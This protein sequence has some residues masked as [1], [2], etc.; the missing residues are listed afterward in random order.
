MIYF[1]SIAASYAPDDA[2]NLGKHQYEYDVNLV[3]ERG[4][5]A[6]AKH[7][8]RMEMFGTND[9]SDDVVLRVGSRVLVWFQDD[10]MTSGVILGCL[11]NNKK[12]MPI[13][14]INRRTRFNK[15]EQKVDRDG[16]WH[17]HLDQ[18]EYVDVTKTHITVSN[19]SGEKIVIDKAAKSIAMQTGGP[20]TV[21]AAGPV[22][23]EA[24]GDVKVTSTGMATVQATKAVVDAKEIELGKDSLEKALNGETFQK[25]FNS[26]THLGNLGAPTSPPTAPSTTAE[27]SGTL[28]VSKG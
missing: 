12:K 13:E 26:H 1:G 21:T 27:L 3:L 22:Q 16:N 14:G 10:A 28:K 18:G 11:R 5:Y 2:G 9:D 4:A 20:W 8:V 15:V 6:F 25:L 17:L 23:I 7:I 24:A 19:S